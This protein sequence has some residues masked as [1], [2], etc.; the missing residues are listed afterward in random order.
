MSW[1]VRQSGL[2]LSQEQLWALLQEQQRK[3]R[4][5]EEKFVV[6]KCKLKDQED[7]FAAQTKK[8]SDFQDYVHDY[9]VPIK[10][11]VLGQKRFS[12]MDMDL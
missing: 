9:I 4:E 1:N 2:I 6:Q 5:Q 12:Q 11:I 7:R 10:Y 8:N 3:S